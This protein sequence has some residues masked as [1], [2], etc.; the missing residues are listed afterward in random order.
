[1]L[2]D[3]V[4]FHA[5]LNPERPG[6]VAF[7]SLGRELS[8]GDL[9][10]RVDAAT[11]A[12]LEAGVAPAK[13]IGV[14]CRD[15][16][17][18]IVLV[19]ALS[20]IGDGAIALSSRGAF[21]PGTLDVLVTDDASR[22]DSV[23]T[24]LIDAAA[25]AASAPQS[26]DPAALLKG[27]GRTWLFETLSI[28]GN[29]LRLRIIERS[30]AKGTGGSS[31]WL[32]AVDIHTELGLSAVLECLWSGGL[33]VLSNG[34]FDDDVPAIALYEADLLFVDANRATSYL[35]AFDRTDRICAP[36]RSALVAGA[37]FDEPSLQRLKQN[38][39]PDTVVYLDTPETGALAACSYWQIDKP[40]RYW[41]LPGVE[42]RISETGHVAVRSETTVGSAPDGWVNSALKGSIAPGGGLDL[43]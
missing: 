23:K 22:K 19:L 20:R 12:L 2:F 39:S 43:A 34:A 4:L 9:V 25:L 36:V 30:R 13:R 21:A 37:A 26:V 27:Q 33:A 29:V 3:P 28:G 32:C 41:P 31:R 5:R 18:Q 24:V 8:Y 35:R 42:V 17:L 11:G 40:R 16:L 1:M 14:H 15:R 7:D 10:R 6:V 38:V